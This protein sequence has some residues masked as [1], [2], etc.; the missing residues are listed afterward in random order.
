MAS[1]SIT[2]QEFG[3]VAHAAR[4]AERRGDMHDARALDKIARKMNAT[5]TY[6]TIKRTSPFVMAVK[7]SWRDMPS[8][9][10]LKRKS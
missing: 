2:E 5:L 6:N 8:T 4:Q 7:P 3:I 10:D 1:I 9:L